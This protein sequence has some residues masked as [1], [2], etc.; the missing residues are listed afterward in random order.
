[1]AANACSNNCSNFYSIAVSCHA[2][3][4]A[5]WPLNEPHT[6]FYTHTH[7]HTHT[8]LH[9]YSH[10]EWRFFFYFFALLCFAFL[11]WSASNAPLT[12]DRRQLEALF[13]FP[14]ANGNQFLFFLCFFLRL[15]CTARAAFGLASN[16]HRPKSVK[17][18]P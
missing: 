5:L 3:V 18:M 11:E 17:L 1:M 16:R 4:S 8:L 2:P 15:H 9:P 10:I 7:L 13:H 6:H 12:A 14:T